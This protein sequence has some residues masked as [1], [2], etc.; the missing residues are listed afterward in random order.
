M[1]TTWGRKRYN[2]IQ[3]VLDLLETLSVYV[4]LGFEIRVDIQGHGGVSLLVLKVAV[5]DLE[6]KI[7]CEKKG[8][9]WMR[10]R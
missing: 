5:E 9:V 2:V 7:D 6:K 3:M 10:Y 4:S 8:F 1:R